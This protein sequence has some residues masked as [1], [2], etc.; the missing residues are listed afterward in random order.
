LKYSLD[1]SLVR[2]LLNCG[3]SGIDMHELSICQGIV[4]EAVKAL[5]RL[6]RMPQ[7]SQ[8]TVRIGRLTRI[9]PE[10]LRQHFDLLVPGTPLEGATLNVEEVPIGG[11]CVDCAASFEMEVLSLVCPECGSGLVELTSGRELAVVSLETA[12]ELSTG[13]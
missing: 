6:P 4:D 12:E 1:S 10:S 5:A 2:I 9:A 3:S 8:V 11:R 7:V 13:D